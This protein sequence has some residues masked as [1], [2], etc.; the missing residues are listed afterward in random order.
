MTQAARRAR[1]V[2]AAALKESGCV[3]TKNKNTE[4]LSKRLLH[5][6]L[7]KAL[8]DRQEL[9]TRH[10]LYAEKA[11]ID[12]EEDQIESAWLADRIDAACR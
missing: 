5:Q 3:L 8:A 9:L 10:Y 1:T 6:K 11:G 2:A 7:D 12:L 4:N